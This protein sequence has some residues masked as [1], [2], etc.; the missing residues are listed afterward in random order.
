MSTPAGNE[1]SEPGESNA[2][3]SETV[4][5]APQPR[6]GFQPFV[7]VVFL[8]FMFFGGTTDQSLLGYDHLSESFPL[9]SLTQYPT[10]LFFR[11]FASISYVSKIKFHSLVEWF[12]YQF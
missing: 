10:R 2:R 8:L 9:Q 1:A 11:V 5:R 6:N 7:I 3:D 4:G 12:R